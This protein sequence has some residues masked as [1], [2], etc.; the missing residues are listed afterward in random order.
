MNRLQ[1][2]SQVIIYKTETGETKIDVRFEDENVWLTQNALAELFQTTKQNIG[3]H[4][5]NVI[6]EGELSK[7]STVKNSFTVQKEGIRE[8]KREIEFYNLDMIISVGYRIK[9]SIATAF[10]QWA[11]LRLREY[12]VKG[13]VLD[14]ERLKNPDLPFDYFEELTRR[15]A[16]IR[17]SEKRFYRKITDIYATSIDYDPESDQ[18]IQFF[19]T[20]QNKVHY[21]VTGNTA[22]EIVI[23]RIDSNKKNLGLTNFRGIKPTNISIL[24]HTAKDRK[25]YNLNMSQ[26]YNPQRTRNMY[27]PSAGSGQAPF[28][29]SR[30][31]LDLFLNCPRCFYLDRKLGVAQPPGYPFSLNSAVDKLLKKEFDIHRKAGTPHP[32]MKKYN[33]DAIPLAHEKLEE[34]QDS[35]RGG[36]T[37]KIE[38][39]NVVITGGVDDVW[40]K[41]DGEFIIVDYKATSKTE[42]VSLDADWQIGYKRQMEI[43]QWLFRKNGFKVCKTGY[44]VYCNGKSDREAFDSK[45]EFDIK[46]IPYEGDDAW[47]E[48]VILDAIECLKS[49][50][51]PPCGEDC[52]FCKYREATA[53]IEK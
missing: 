28:R 53:Q 34:W 42:E 23:G 47:V 8:I 15:I 51:L 1:S 6:E 49:D 10:R 30:G 24:K 5:K 9:S 19:K 17:T 39:E 41:Q 20:V 44:F 52:D 40:V 33:V 22:A 25:R 16:D 27:D 43:Y 38:E 12:I 11:T 31:K 45:L 3:Q 18:S 32:L 50:K 2:Q 29:L 46:I 36:I 7:N 35:L 13:F 48:K 14:D 4:I 26:Y 37:L 21:A